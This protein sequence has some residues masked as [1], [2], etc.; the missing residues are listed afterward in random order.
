MHVRRKWPSLHDLPNRELDSL[1]DVKLHYEDTE[2]HDGGVRNDKWWEHLQDIHNFLLGLQDCKS[3]DGQELMSIL[4]AQIYDLS[5]AIYV[6]LHHFTIDPDKP[7]NLR[8]KG[9]SI[10]GDEKSV[11]FSLCEST[12]SEVLRGWFGKRFLA[13]MVEI[14]Q[15]QWIS[16][17]FDRK[18][19][20][21]EGK[22]AHLYIF[23]PNISGRSERAVHVVHMWRQVLRVM[24]YPFHFT[25]F[26][27]PLSNQEK[28]WAVGYVALFCLLQTLRGIV[29]DTIME[30]HPK[31]WHRLQMET[32]HHSHN[33]HETLFTTKR[34]RRGDSEL[35]F[36]DWRA[37]ISNPKDEDKPNVAL[38]WVLSYLTGC[39]AMELGIKSHIC[40]SAANPLRRIEF[41]LSRLSTNNWQTLDANK[42]TTV[43]GG[44]IPI[45]PSF[46]R[47]DKF[48]CSWGGLNLGRTFRG[49][50]SQW[51]VI[52]P[53]YRLPNSKA[54]KPKDKECDPNFILPR[55]I[56]KARKKRRERFEEAEKKRK[57]GE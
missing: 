31:G 48:G 17:I 46:A 6:P 5:D 20:L 35:R 27:I 10:Y 52:N 53:L 47:H 38:A 12:V 42:L 41:N 55:A 32:G 29:G 26:S 45:I 15:G 13:C 43:F 23:D 44:F 28:K 37:C 40:F 36:R 14:G 50:F 7:V 2:K 3:P 16:I 1:E 56:Q 49:P 24:G 34:K 4:R 9:R 21:V 33:D 57:F 54:I 39:A 22:E 30:I 8:P 19:D 51:G 25:A 11:T 18:R